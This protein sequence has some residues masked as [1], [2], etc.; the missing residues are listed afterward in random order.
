MRP[1]YSTR[2]EVKAEL[3][4]RETARS[5]ARVDRAIEAACDTVDGFLHRVFYPDTDTRYFDWPNAQTAPSWRLWLDANEV[6][7][8]SALSSGGTTIAASSYFLEPNTYGPPYNRI[9]INLGSSAAFG[10]G[11]T[12]QRDI[13]VTGLFGYRNDETTLGAT[14]EAL[15]ASET[16]VDVDGATSAEV[17]VGSLL[18]IDDERV[19]VTGRAQLD[20]GQ[21]LGGNLTAVNSDVAVSVS[22]GTAYAVDE[23]ILIDSEKMRI[24]D[25]AG[26]T[27]MV[28]RAWDGTTLAA[29]TAGA[30]IYAPRTLTVQ[31]AAVGTT[32]ATHTTSAAVYRWDPPAAVRQLAL[33]EALNDLLQGRS[34]YAR[35]A[36]AGENEREMTGR[37]LEALRKR[38]YVSHG[39]KARIRG[40]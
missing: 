31:R 40:V 35:T 2:E 4:V 33:A 8:V 39:R 16:G 1:W 12:H 21:N 30:D 6:V 37:G 7:S 38:V 29:H 5:N 28:T 9:E 11:D 19:I 13:T 32:A 25:I 26:N 27:L 14:V 17:G 36:G 18:R 23:V 3:D 20:T 34:G 24:D 22:D 15:D 10:G